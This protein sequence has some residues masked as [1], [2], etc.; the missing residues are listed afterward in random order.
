MAAVLNSCNVDTKGE[1]SPVFSNAISK[2]FPRHLRQEFNTKDEV[3]KAHKAI[4]KMF[5]EYSRQ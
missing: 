5:S 2:Y 3:D 4:D 1:Q